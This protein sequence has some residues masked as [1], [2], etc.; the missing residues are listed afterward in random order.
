MSKRFDVFILPKSTSSNEI[1]ACGCRGAV[2]AY[3]FCQC[4]ESKKNLTVIPSTTTII[5]LLLAKLSHAYLRVD[6]LF[7]SKWAE[8]SHQ[9][10]P[11]YNW[12]SGSAI[13][14]IRYG[15]NQLEKPT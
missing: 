10:I 15:N 9:G 11:K 5:D 4:C 12:L 14:D 8:P 6:F 3:S 13:L 7:D 1:H 2:H